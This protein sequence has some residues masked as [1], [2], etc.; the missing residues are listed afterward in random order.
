MSTPDSEAG[1][2]L[3]ANDIILPD[4]NTAPIDGWVY[5][6]LKKVTD[7][8]EAPVLQKAMI[9]A[10]SNARYQSMDGVDIGQIVGFDNLQR[11]NNH[12]YPPSHRNA[13]VGPFSLED[14]WKHIQTVFAAAADFYKDIKKDYAPVLNIRP[15]Q[16]VLALTDDESRV[17]QLG[18][19]A[20][21][22][23]LGPALK[24][25]SKPLGSQDKLL[26]LALDMSPQAVRQA[27]QKLQAEGILRAA[28]ST[29]VSNMDPSTGL[30]YAA[31]YNQAELPT[32]NP[33]L[34]FLA[35]GSEYSADEIRI[36]L[37][38]QTATPDPTLK[39]LKDFDYIPAKDT[40][41]LLKLLSKPYAPGEKRPLIILFGD[42]GTGKTE[43]AKM[44]CAAAGKE[45]KLAGEPKPGGGPVPHAEL[46]ADLAIKL[47]IAERTGGMIIGVDEAERLNADTSGPDQKNNAAKIILNRLGENTAAPVILI[48]NSR[49]F[50]VSVF[51]RASYIVG[52]PGQSREFTERL[53]K[54]IA[55]NIGVRLPAKNTAKLLDR[56][57]NVPPALIK[58]ALEN[59]KIS[60]QPN[61]GTVVQTLDSLLPNVRGTTRPTA[62]QPT[63][64]IP[65]EPASVAALTST[66]DTLPALLEKIPGKIAFPSFLVTGLPGNGEDG[67]AH[68][69]ASRFGNKP[70]Q[71]V[72]TSALSR[73]KELTDAFNKS[74][75]TGS[76][77]IIDDRAARKS[78]MTP[79]FYDELREN[80]LRNDVHT[81]MLTDSSMSPLYAPFFGYTVETKTPTAKIV[82]ALL[83][84]NQEKSLPEQ[85]TLLDCFK[86]AKQ[87]ATENHQTALPDAEIHERL[88]TMVKM[89]TRQGGPA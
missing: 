88:E 63:P 36:S 8:I 74:Y 22:S 31:G 28:D 51:R 59:H 33:A 64:Q 89:R 41:F 75:D 34:R 86:L 38:G 10:F 30:F 71:F 82:A 46:I 87:L 56:F 17:F 45:F 44:L 18:L 15:L 13:Q 54:R 7:K 37:L 84:L 62:P 49:D 21:N 65:Y 57:G 16:A 43:Y 26:G 70:P 4:F 60:P 11:L 61:A 73:P 27:T 3:P 32:P 29:P 42:V 24:A 39:L 77:L 20:Q 19:I 12:N 2:S 48:C 81:V 76:V 79:F 68:E 40:Q 72:N 14:T 5:H 83:H 23:P 35:S 67:I 58:T 69:I 1:Q 47:R 52:F 78:G 50:D 53:W 9:T 25:F 85:T 66:G 80:V 6:Y 55:K